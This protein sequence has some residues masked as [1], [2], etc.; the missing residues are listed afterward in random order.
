[1]SEPDFDIEQAKMS[2]V[3]VYGGKWKFE[4]QQLCC[5]CRRVERKEPRDNM[6]SIAYFP[7]CDGDYAWVLLQCLDCGELNCVLVERKEAEEDV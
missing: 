1:M 4:K 3:R 7:I 5:P 2:N 6:S